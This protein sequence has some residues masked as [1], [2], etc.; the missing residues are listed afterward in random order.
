MKVMI[1]SELIHANENGDA[2]IGKNLEVNGTTKLN[3]EIKPIHT[4]PLGDYTFSVLFERHI[5][6]S[7]DHI[8]FGYIIYDDG[9]SAACIGIYSAAKDTLTSFN[10]ISHSAIYSWV[11]GSTLEEKMIA[12]MS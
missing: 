8:F 9:S 3:G 10:A 4:F 2:V 5:E 12:T 1:P 11:A 7:T 6:P